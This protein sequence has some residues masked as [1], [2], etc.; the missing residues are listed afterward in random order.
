MAHHTE[1]WGRQTARER[2]GKV[3][4]DFGKTESNQPQFEIDS[5]GPGYDND[6]ANKSWLRSN[7]EAKPGFDHKRRG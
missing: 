3:K 1:K 7:A 2:Y 6:V 5:H 4:S